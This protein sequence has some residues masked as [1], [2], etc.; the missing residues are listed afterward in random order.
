MTR[1]SQKIEEHWHIEPDQEVLHTP[2]GTIRKG[3][4]QSRTTLKRKDFYFFDFP[5]AMKTS[6]KASRFPRQG[7]WL[8]NPGHEIKIRSGAEG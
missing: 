2:I 3:P 8:Q 1:I 7:P 4:L 5:E 6:W